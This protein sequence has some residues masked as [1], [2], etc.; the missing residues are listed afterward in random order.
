MPHF[1]PVPL[2]ALSCSQLKGSLGAAITSKP[3]PL[4]SPHSFTRTQQA[5]RAH[6]GVRENRSTSQAN[7]VTMA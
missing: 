6:R 7:E 1:L 5:L 2:P 4:L 3:G